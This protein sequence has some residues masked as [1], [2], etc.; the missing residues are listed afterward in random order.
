MPP[1][2]RTLSDAVCLGC[3]CLCDDVR[4]TIAGRRVESVEGGCPEAA[5]WFTQP[6]VPA[7]DACFIAGQPASL[8]E[9][10]A[11]AAE[12]LTAERSPVVAGLAGVS[13]EAQ[14][15]AVAIADRIGGGVVG[16][17]TAG[18][19]AA[20]AQAV[21]SH[22]AVTA[23]LG[24]AAQRADRIVFW[25][26]DPAATHPRHF[27]RFSLQPTSEWLPR[28]RADRTVYAIGSP[29][30]RTAA[31]ADHV[32]PLEPERDY[33]AFGVLHALAQG[34]ALDPAAVRTATGVELADWRRL[35]DAL[36]G[37]RY[38]AVFYDELFS[39][40]SDNR[41]TTTGAVSLGALTG[42]LAELQTTTRAAALPL[43]ARRYRSNA[44]GAS[45]VLA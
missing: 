23:T 34:V 16:G 3:A 13:V 28:G 4:L 44:V 38:A 14:R 8:A 43:G 33:E 32:I 9:A 22:G 19:G 20:L 39:A 12:L 2:T 15:L 37:G 35:A 7:E 40:L 10:T 6:I 11:A 21:A 45:N 24:E 30:T 17:D 18:D 29:S 41:R 1:E 5:G 36:A 26:C 42:W 31:A 25:R 27:D